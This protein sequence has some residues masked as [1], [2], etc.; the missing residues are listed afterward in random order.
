MFLSQLVMLLE[1]M[2]RYSILLFDFLFS[3]LYEKLD[4]DDIFV[5]RNLIN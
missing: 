4:K 3:L 1:A 5:F 2:L